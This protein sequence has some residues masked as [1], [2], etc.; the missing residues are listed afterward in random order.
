MV[1]EL[2]GDDA[3][4]I[5]RTATGLVLAAAG[6]EASNTAAGTVVLLPTDPDASA[7]RLRTE[8]HRRT[9]LT[10]VGIL[11]SDTM[12]RPWRLGQTDT[13]IGVAGVVPLRDETGCL[14]R[15]GNLLQVTAAAIADELAAAG[16]LTRTKSSGHA[17]VIVRGVGAHVSP[18][19]GPGARALVR[20]I[21][22]DL[23]HTGADAAYAAG[24]TAAVSSRRT[25]RAF[26]DEPVDPDL[27][28]AA[29]SDAITAPSPH[30]TTPWRFL[31]IADPGLRRKLLD[32]MRAQWEADLAQIDGFTAE[33]I[34]K[35]TKRG[36]VLR[37]A[38]AL[39]LPF[40]DFAAATH[41][42]PDERRRGF[43]R[44]L[45]MMSGGAA[46]QNLLVG[47]SSR[48]LGSAW[49][50]ATVFC[51]ETVREVLNL[52][53][54]YQPYGAVAAGHPAE[55]AKQRPSKKVADYLRV[56]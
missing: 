10:R 54:T 26:T 36:D 13:A 11:I 4:A 42:Y 46:V 51:P 27:I 29:V 22:E 2:P 52:P 43:E 33:S 1:A 16:D 34:Q 30:H 9:G 37:Q 47:L 19:D 45:F 18:D 56:M 5:V 15:D 25:I 8:L 35:R 3:S 21:E 6:V 38:P 17:V 48:G 40:L 44:D 31:R 23:F 53:K 7:A 41:N 49:I 20:P 14:D 55:S 50:S 39:I 32:A 12:G 28:V 24:L